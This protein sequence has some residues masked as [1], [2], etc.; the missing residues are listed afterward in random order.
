M[1]NQVIFIRSSATRCGE[2]I[3]SVRKALYVYGVAI[4]VELQHGPYKGK[5]VD[6]V[7]LSTTRSDLTLS[8]SNRSGMIES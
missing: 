6:V 4:Q 5:V 7:V 8:W 2:L 3:K 1:S